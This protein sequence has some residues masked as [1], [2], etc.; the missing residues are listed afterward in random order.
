MKTTLGKTNMWIKYRTCHA[1]GVSK[2]HWTEMEKESGYN[3]NKKDNVVAFLEEK[4]D[5]SWSD[6]FRGY[7]WTKH[8][9]PPKEQIE[10]R[11]KSLKSRIK[12]S[13]EKIKE[14]QNYYKE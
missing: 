9:K 12:E 3:P 1:W 6:K 2:W 14:L 5:F 7:E 10:G 4:E 13:R 8:K 11:I